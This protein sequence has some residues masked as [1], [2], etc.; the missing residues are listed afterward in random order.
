MYG[1]DD[2][3]IIANGKG[4]MKKP[5]FNLA[6]KSIYTYWLDTH[7]KILKKLERKSYV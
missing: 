7:F 6:H 1:T 4:N 2:T 3:D 5:K